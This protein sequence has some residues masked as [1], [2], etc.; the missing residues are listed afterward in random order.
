MTLA[1]DSK[2]IPYTEQHSFEFLDQLFGT[3]A[4][5][6]TLHNMKRGLESEL[7][8]LDESIKGFTEI[9]AQ[10]HEEWLAS[11]NSTAGSHQER[12]YQDAVASASEQ[13]MERKA[14]LRET[15][16]DMLNYMHTLISL[17]DERGSRAYHEHEAG[18][19]YYRKKEA[20]DVYL[21]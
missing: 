15:L 11:Q 18:M 14:E 1:K 6:S 2:G 8:D 19:E 3:G 7:R 13:F 21:S 12:D 9:D 16:N 10:H 17:H 4:T 5:A 20:L